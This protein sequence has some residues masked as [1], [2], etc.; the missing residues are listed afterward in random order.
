MTT[1][2]DARGRL[3]GMFTGSRAGD[4]PSVLPGQPLRPTTDETPAQRSARM[5][6]EAAAYRDA[7]A[8]T[9]GV[10]SA[11]LLEFLC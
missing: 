4:A 5:V 9:R 3:T 6:L 8:T 2:L 10:L 1:A 7:L 11:T